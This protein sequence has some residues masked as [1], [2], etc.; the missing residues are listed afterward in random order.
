MSLDQLS[1]CGI[2]YAQPGIGTGALICVLY[3]WTCLVAEGTE[4]A[5]MTTER[6]R[7]TEVHLEKPDVWNADAQIGGRYAMCVPH[8]PRGGYISMAH[9]PTLALGTRMRVR[10]RVRARAQI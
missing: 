4:D 10:V 5:A 9:A 1:G 2:Q 6:L 8:G 3:S 7:A